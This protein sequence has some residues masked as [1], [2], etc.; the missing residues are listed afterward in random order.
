M[1]GGFKAPGQDVNA[2]L[3]LIED[4]K[5]ADLSIDLEILVHLAPADE[6]CDVGVLA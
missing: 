6:L 4:A 5:G 3:R 2:P 1:F